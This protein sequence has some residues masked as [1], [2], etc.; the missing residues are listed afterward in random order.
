MLDENIPVISYLI[1][2]LGYVLQG[3]YVDGRFSAP[4][5]GL[6]SNLGRM[7]VLSVGDSSIGQSAAMNYYIAS[8]NGLMGDSNLEAAQILA[9]SEHLKE[10]MAAWRV[11]V[12]YGV[13]PTA[14]VLTTWF[15]TGATDVTGTA[16]G[17][18]RSTRFAQWWMGRIEAILGANGFAV[19]NK[20]SLADVLI[21]NTFAETLDAAQAPADMPQWKKESFGSKAHVDAALAKH[22]KLKASCDAVAANANAQKWLSS[23]GVQYF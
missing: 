16:V 15:E 13:E 9:I 14:E 12:P 3:D 10:L 11:L 7:P 18:T 22:P 2:F 5:E 4:P 20:L 8:E 6:E 19:G 1:L 21:Y 17:D 23:R